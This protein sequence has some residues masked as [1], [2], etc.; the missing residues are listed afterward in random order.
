MATAEPRS[1]KRGTSALNRLGSAFGVELV[2]SFPVPHIAPPTAGEPRRS[3][4]VEPTTTDE[5][6]RRWRARGVESGG[7]RP[8]P[9]GR[10]V[11][12]V[13]D[14]RYPDG[15]PFMLIDR[16]PELGYRIWAPRYGRYEVSHDGRSIACAIP[17]HS[18]RWERLF[19]AQVM[20]LAAALQRVELFHASAVSLDGR[21]V[22]FAAP[23]GTG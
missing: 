4:S 2:G 6:Q 19:F 5:I 16:H 15:R 14:R 21:A 10:A 18:L 7:D 22:A 8:D 17:P 9:D 13:C 11:E 3:V 12:S 23:S 20:P 1:K